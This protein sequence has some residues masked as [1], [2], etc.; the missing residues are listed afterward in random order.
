MVYCQAYGCRNA[1][2]KG[3]EKYFH[4][5]PNKEKKP[6]LFRKWAAAMKVEK[7]LKPSYK[8]NRNDV[9]CSDHFHEDDWEVDMRAKLRGSKP[10]NILKEHAVPS[11]FLH[12]TSKAARETTVSRIFVLESRRVSK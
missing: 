8:F 4:T 2:G 12:K 6:E 3:L 10:R 7:F 5:I 9:L 1:S 11:V